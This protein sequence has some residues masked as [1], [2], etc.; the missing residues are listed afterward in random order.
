MHVQLAMYRALLRDYNEA[1]VTRILGGYLARFVEGS[2]QSVIYG[3][4]I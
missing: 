4:S 3:G 2:S 1:D